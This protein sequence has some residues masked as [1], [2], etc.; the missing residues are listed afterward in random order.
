VKIATRGRVI[1][2]ADGCVDN[3]KRVIQPKGRSTHHVITKADSGDKKLLEVFN[4]E[5]FKIEPINKKITT[6]FH[7]N[8]K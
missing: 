3:K 1:V 6:N 7:L 4:I 2:G 5:N 8:K